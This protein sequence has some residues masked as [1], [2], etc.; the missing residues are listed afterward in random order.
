MKSISHV[1]QRENSIGLYYFTLMAMINHTK[2]KDYISALDT[3]ETK[4]AAARA[5][6]MIAKAIGFSNCDT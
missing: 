1:S 6:Y 5:E 4:E 2:C 3:I